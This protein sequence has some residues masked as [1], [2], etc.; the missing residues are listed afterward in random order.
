MHTGFLTAYSTFKNTII[1]KLATLKK[2][3]P[4]AQTLL[5]GHSLGGAMATL[6]IPD[7][8]EEIDGIDF[9]YSFGS[10]RVGNSDFANFIN[11]FFLKGGYSARVT[12]NQDLVPH[13]PEKF[14]GYKHIDNEVYYDEKSQDFSICQN[15]EK[16]C[17]NENLMNPSIQDHKNYM[18]V[19]TSYSKFCRNG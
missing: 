9:F 1:P 18:G 8:F 2:K 5:T 7:L 14:L 11:D 15:D 4:Y 17:S 19:P 12:H 13:L 6:A 16:G 3:Y 10:P